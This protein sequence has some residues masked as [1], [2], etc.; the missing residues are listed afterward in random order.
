MIA[1]VAAP[2]SL[3]LCGGGITGAMYEFGAL[4]ALDHACGGKFLSTQYDVYV[5]TSGG[6]V[7][8]ALMANGVSPAEVGRAILHNSDD[9]LNFRQEDIV[10]ID[11]R[12]I[13]HS[14]VKG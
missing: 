4:H 10:R 2:R 11:W 12:E 6:A 14:F 9:P 7:V 3:V 8:A 5:G 13:R 1:P